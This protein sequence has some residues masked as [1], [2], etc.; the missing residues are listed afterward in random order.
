M[1]INWGIVSAGNIANQF[2]HDLKFN[3]TSLEK[4]FTHKVVSIGSSSIEKGEKWILDNELTSENNGG[5]TPKVE[6]YSSFYSNPDINVVYVASPHHAHKSQVFECLNN[7]KHVLVEKPITLNRKDALDI[8]ELAKKKN[9][10][11]M[12]AVWTRFFPC[13]LELK[14]LVY[15]D[16]ILGDISRLFVDF[17]YDANVANLPSSHRVRDRKIGAGALLDIGI[18]AM[19]YARVL[20]DEKIGKSHS[21]FDIKSFLN[22]DPVDK[23]DHYGSALINY[24]DGKLAILSWSEYTPVKKPYASLEGTLGHAEFYGEN[25]ACP[26]KIIVKLNDPSKDDIVLKLDKNYNGFIY[27]ANAVAED[28]LDGKLQNDI[29]PHDESLLVMGMMDEIRATAN[30]K[31]PHEE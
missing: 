28:I 30:F 19:T 13:L 21:E 5:V 7:G 31:Y 15:K 2:V 11:V 29:C 14:K 27:E 3:N 6:L 24:A 18:Y 12:E 25:P 22:L 16:K 10:F 9:L 17:C 1:S 26:Q 20:L 23:V 8:F 4:K